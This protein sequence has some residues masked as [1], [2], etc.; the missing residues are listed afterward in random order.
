MNLKL[1][2]FLTWI[3]F[4]MERRT[5]DDLWLGCMVYCGVLAIC[6]YF[7]RKDNSAKSTTQ[8]TD[9]GKSE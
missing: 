1:L 6:V 2:I 8:Q 3:F 4:I 5:A 9:G 7:Y